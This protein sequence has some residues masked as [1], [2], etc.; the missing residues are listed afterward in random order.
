MKKHY[1]IINIFWSD[2][3]NLYIAEV[4]ELEGCITHGVSTMEAAN[5]AENAITS[6]IQTAKKL[7]HPIPEPVSTR[8]VS[9]KF[10]VRLPKAVHKN[11]VIKAIQEGVSLN[12]MVT[13]LLAKSL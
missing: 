1:Y 6:W 8:K 7:G 2:E 11:L 4:P 3:D 5:N 9:G 13:T 10:N 12:Q